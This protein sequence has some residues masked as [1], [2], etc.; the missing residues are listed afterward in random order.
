MTIGRR[1]LILGALGFLG[2]C[3]SSQRL[4]GA[5]DE[6]SLGGLFPNSP[7]LS[8]YAA[9]TDE[10]YPVPAIN[11]STVKQRFLRREVEFTTTEKPGTLVIDSA[12]RYAYLVQPNGR[13]LRYG[14]G[15]GK[16]E[17]L[18]FKGEAV[19]GR[20]AK[21]PRWTPTA[22]MIERE[23]RYVKFAS[24]MEGGAENPLGPRALYL[25][26]NGRDTLFRLHGT[27]QPSTI[28]SMVSS[29]CVRFINQDI[30]DLYDRVPVGT[31]VVVL[32]S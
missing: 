25:Y 18:Q 24:G 9:M 3:S 5:Q 26:K 4:A 21:W 20:K 6:F 30:I 14:V 1:A 22:D 13:A 15:V 8:A 19:V 10:P 29:G 27:L 2:G 11:L 12:N 7:E 31:K 16:T 28:G 17:A 23:P 32:Q